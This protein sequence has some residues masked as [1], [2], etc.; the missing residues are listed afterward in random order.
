MGDRLVARVD[1]KADRAN[2]RLLA[3][4]VFAEPGV[5]PG[6]VAAALAGE[7]KLLAGWLG[8]ARVV[9]GRRG[10][11]TAPLRSHLAGAAGKVV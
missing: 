1:L 8:L 4:G 2:G 9:V 5:D 11:L 10:D 3:S 6:E 7:L